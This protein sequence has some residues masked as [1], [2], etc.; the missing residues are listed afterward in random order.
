M[1]AREKELS[2]MEDKYNN[3]KFEFLVMYG[4]RRVGKNYDSQRD[5]KKT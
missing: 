3:N 4:R 1:I 5:C 2:I